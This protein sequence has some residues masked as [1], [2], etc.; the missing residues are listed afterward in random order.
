MTLRN[1]THDETFVKQSSQYAQQSH[2]LEPQLDS[3]CSQLQVTSAHDVSL[4]CIPI[5]L[6]RFELDLSLQW[7]L[8]AENSLVITFTIATD[9]IIG[10]VAFVKRCIDPSYVKHLHSMAID[11][12][13]QSP[14]AVWLLKSTTSLS[15]TAVSTF[16]IQEATRA[17][18]ECSH[19]FP[20]LAQNT[21]SDILESIRELANT[22][23][24]FSTSLRT[25]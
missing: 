4:L 22:V 14:T 25:S 16:R 18:S 8:A 2:Q 21:S 12:P 1:L 13:L 10:S 6:D 19:A 23:G 20:W 15:T 11:L 7:K 3:Q 24:S 9:L 17:L 5:S